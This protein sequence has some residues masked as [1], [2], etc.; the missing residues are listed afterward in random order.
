LRVDTLPDESLSEGQI[1]AIA[2]LLDRV[3]PK[4]LDSLSELVGLFMEKRRRRRVSD[5]RSTRPPQRHLVWRES[6]LMAHALTFERSVVAEGE[7]VAVMALSQ[8]C[9]S[10]NARGGGLGRAV[11]LHALRRVDEKEFQLSLFQTGVPDFYRKL[12]ARV[13][14]NSFVDS[15]N[16]LAPDA[17]P[18]SDEWI[19][20]YP[21]DSGWPRGTVD[22][23]GP[24]Y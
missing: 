3:W 5:P 9:V 7:E 20:I 21:S 13:V 23:N 4:D 16:R 22:L 19:M 8:V 17:N 12:G 15:T 2:T 10:P 14:E 6:D 18:W 11:A 24:A 1:Q